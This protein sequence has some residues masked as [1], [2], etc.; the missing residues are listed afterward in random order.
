MAT[1]SIFHQ[2]VIDTDEKAERFV[3]ALKSSE[4]KAKERPFV[5]RENPYDSFT[6]EEKEKIKRTIKFK[7]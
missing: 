1:S 3:K 4:K 5:P 7:L 2:V 6:D